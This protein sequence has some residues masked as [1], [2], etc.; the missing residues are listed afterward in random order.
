LGGTQYGNVFPVFLSQTLGDASIP[1]IWQYCTGRVLEGIADSLGDTQIRRLITE[2]RAKQATVDMGK[3]TGA[4]RK[5]LDGYI[6]TTIASEWKPTWLT[7]DVWIS[8]PYARTTM[9]NN[10]TLTPEYRTTPG[11]S[12]ANQIPLFVKGDSVFVNFKPIGKNMKCQICYRDILGNAVYGTPVDSGPCSMLLAT[13]PANDVVIAVISNTD[14]IF[15]GDKTCKKHFDYRL[16]IDTN[17]VVP[18]HTQKRWYAWDQDPASD[19]TSALA[20]ISSPDTLA[21]TDIALTLNTIYE[22]DKVGTATGKLSTTD[23]NHVTAQD[24]TLV[25][26]YGD[27]DNG[28]FKISGSTL[29]TKKLLDYETKQTYTVRVRSTNLT[30]KFVEKTFEIPIQD[31]AETSVESHFKNSSTIL[32]YPNPVNQTATVK[33]LTDGTIQKI[34]IFNLAGSVVKVINNINSGECT[35][36]KDNLPNGIYYLKV[37]SS[38]NN[39]VKLIFK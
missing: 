38:E 35:I 25:S 19:V 15:E 26:G 32:V 30:G 5:L 3:W 39:I 27:T 28:S 29:Q 11:W 8:T 37:N 17:L 20:A 10:G 4:I 34:E 9:D 16:Q 13:P 23:P 6:N 14:Y 31:V 2:Y 22:S 18:A 21:P 12:G 33:L 24:Y 7:P 36:N 1:W